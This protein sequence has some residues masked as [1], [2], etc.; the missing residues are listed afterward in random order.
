MNPAVSNKFVV[1]SANLKTTNTKTHDST[2]AAK[3][4]SLSFSALNYFVLKRMG[5]ETSSN[6]INLT[7]PMP[8]G[9]MAPHPKQ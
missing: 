3:H 9:T 7:T 6:V 4:I 1:C 5:F 2:A 8:L